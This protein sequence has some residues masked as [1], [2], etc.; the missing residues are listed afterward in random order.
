MSF[1]T[2]KTSSRLTEIVL[3]T[4]ADAR[5]RAGTLQYKGGSWS[6]RE[7]SWMQITQR[8]GNPAYYSSVGLSFR[9]HLPGR[10]P[11]GD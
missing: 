10:A 9:V 6:N 7:Q 5:A 8:H 3:H 4:T 11:R 1:G 2:G